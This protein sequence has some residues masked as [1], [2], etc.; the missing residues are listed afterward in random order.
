MQ[1]FLD[2]I[3]ARILAIYLC[4]YCGRKLWYGLV[5]RKIA[6]FNDD[7]IDWL[8][9]D[10]SKVVADRDA[11]P[12]R[13]W[14]L[15]GLRLICVVG[16]LGVMGGGD[17]TLEP[18]DLALGRPSRHGSERDQHTRHAIIVAWGAWD[19]GPKLELLYTQ[20]STQRRVK[21]IVPRPMQ[22]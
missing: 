20:P 15:I 12:I 3:A 2:Q 7:F 5:E 18:A 8:L 22:R 11:T 16:C 1:F 13:Y 19:F 9:M 14:I 17:Q 6:Y 4:V 21:K 10:W